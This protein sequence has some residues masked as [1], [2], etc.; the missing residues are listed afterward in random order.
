M[1]MSFGNRLAGLRKKIGKLQTEVAKDI[2][3]ARATYG[4]YE[5][6]KREPDLMTLEKLANYYEVSIDYLVKGEDYRSQA[7]KLLND[8]NTQVAARDGDMS[9][10][11][12]MDAIAW[13]LEQEKGRKPG[14]KQK[15]K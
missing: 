7:E 2:G 15:R 4:A 14:E 1:S 5:Q 11:K 13:L 8:P 10:D 12:A 9:K 6:D 3:V